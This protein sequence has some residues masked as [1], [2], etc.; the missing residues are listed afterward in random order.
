MLEDPPLPLVLG[1]DQH[2]QLDSFFYTFGSSLI[3]L[4]PFEVLIAANISINAA[5]SLITIFVRELISNAD[6]R[7]DILRE[8]WK[9]HIVRPPYVDVP[10]S[11]HLV[12]L[13]SHTLRGEIAPRLYK[14]AH[15]E[16]LL[17]LQIMLPDVEGRIAT[18]AF[19]DFNDFN[20]FRDDC[21]GTLCNIELPSFSESRSD[22]LCIETA[23][24]RIRGM[25]KLIRPK[26][27]MCMKLKHAR[28]VEL[29]KELKLIM[30]EN[31]GGYRFE[32][33]LPPAESI[34]TME[35]VRNI[36]HGKIG[37]IW[38]VEPPAYDQ[39]TRLSRRSSM[40]E[41]AEK[42]SPYGLFHDN[43]DKKYIHHEDLRGAAR[44]HGAGYLWWK[45]SPELESFIELEIKQ[46][47]QN[48]TKD[49]TK[50]MVSLVAAL[51]GLDATK[52]LVAKYP[53]TSDHPW[54]QVILDAYEGTIDPSV[55]A[56]NLMAGP[57]NLNDSHD[58][59]DLN[60]S[61]DQGKAG[62]LI[63][64]ADPTDP[65]NPTQQE[66]D[67]MYQETLPSGCRVVWCDTQHG[68]P[69][70][71][72]ASVS[73]SAGSE[74]APLG[75]PEVANISEHMLALL[76]SP[77]FP[78]GQ[79]NKRRLSKY[80]LDTNAWTSDLRTAYHASGSIEPITRVYIPMVSA[81]LSTRP[82][83]LDESMITSE[84]NAVIK[85]LEAI[86]ED[87][88]VQTIL[89]M[90][91]TLYPGTQR[92]RD[93]ED[94]IEYTKRLLD[95]VPRAIREVKSFVEHNYVPR[96][97]VITVCS[98]RSR[99]NDMVHAATILAKSLSNLSTVAVRDGFRMRP[100]LPSDPMVK[101]N[102]EA[103]RLVVV[104]EP[105]AQTIAK[106]IVVYR[107]RGLTDSEENHTELLCFD[108]L[109]HTLTGSVSCRL[110]TRLRDEL[111][112]VYSVHSSIEMGV[113]NRE[114][115]FLV[116]ETLCDPHR[117]EDVSAEVT[118]VMN[119]IR[120]DGIT[121]SELIS[122]KR[123]TVPG[124]QETHS[125]ASPS[126]V[127]EIHDHDIAHAQTLRGAI[128]KCANVERLT[129]AEVRGA[130]LKRLST[131]PMIFVGFNRR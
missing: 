92:A 109:T 47:K 23:Y 63:V 30:K 55:A 48:A 115:G 122:Y 26:L 22:A 74:A 45:I 54:P 120:D 24:A 102:W 28:L 65:T 3:T 84:L 17:F 15:I 11:V 107:I 77:R 20:N 114:I 117:V 19:N 116:I 39:V 87:Q 121:P 12:H 95:D 9:R 7:H 21:R 93:V 100:Q 85:E 4:C 88:W 13:D 73:Y 130:I 61:V 69:D 5:S 42:D 50:K 6:L 18:R 94:G 98:H 71:G 34:L 75:Q 79:R 106:C 82:V 64:S 68:H 131:D 104:S 16:D 90:N 44:S 67:I 29:L 81:M 124:I 89:E 127:A 128:S 86:K 51:I 97:C 129:L 96:R 2:P 36:Q 103:N 70:I 125:N 76:T 1:V 110:M 49:H 33:L 111:E 78:D 72:F 43:D 60:D 105:S 91:K 80:G 112:L 113:T 123:N 108:A 58:S 101:P 62:R 52:M 40:F 66:S 53:V 83:V 59:H 35:D 32:D 99:K 46:R 27:I 126:T 14:E 37:H 10:L 8:P 57:L 118:K 38:V 25:R 41:N 119:S 56:K 31:D